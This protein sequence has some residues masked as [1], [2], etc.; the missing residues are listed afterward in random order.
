MDDPATMSPS[1]PPPLRP[2]VKALVGF[3]AIGGLLFGYDA[4]I[5]SGALVKLRER[6]ALSPT[7]QELIV[8]TSIAVA[9]L[10]SLVGGYLN[11]WLGRR[12]VTLI[13]SALLTAGAAVSAATP[14]KE[15]LLVGRSLIGLGIGNDLAIAICF[16][17]SQ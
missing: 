3:A 13:A 1:P 6:F 17:F 15:I 10:S 9:T 14:T 5:L 11:D 2:L 7:W 8:S 12:I 16:S 4:G